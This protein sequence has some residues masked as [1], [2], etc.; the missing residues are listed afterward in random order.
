MPANRRSKLLCAV[1]CCVLFIRW[2]LVVV[3]LGIGGGARKANMV[4][5]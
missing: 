3:G 2:Q 5:A 1:V 4:L